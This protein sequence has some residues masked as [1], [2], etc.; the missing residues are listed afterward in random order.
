MV[1]E[2][3]GVGRLWRKLARGLEVK[4][5]IL[6]AIEEEERHNGEDC[7]RAALK[8]WYESN[9]SCATTRDIMICLTNM[10][11]GSINWHVMKELKLVAEADMPQAERS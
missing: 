1:A 11:Y 7:C 10:G 8:K 3:L 4:G 2:K 9:G 6:D 5:A